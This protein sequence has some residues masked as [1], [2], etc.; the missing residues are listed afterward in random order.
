MVIMRRTI[1]V[2][3]LLALSLS[4]FTQTKESV[5]NQAYYEGQ[6]VGSIDLVANPRIDL[7]PY[8]SLIVQKAGEPYSSDKVA[9]SVKALENTQAFSGVE[10]Q[11]NPDPA[12]LKL[13]FVLE[14]VYYIGMITFPG[15]IKRFSYTRLLQIANLQDQSPYQSSQ[16]QQSESALLRFFA[17]QGYFQAK[18]ALEVK[19]DDQNQLTNIAFHTEL[20]KQARVGK[21]EIVGPPAREGQKLESRLRSLRARFTGALVKTGKPY[22]QTRIRSAMTLIKKELGKQNYLANTVKANPP[23]YHPETN[24]ADVSFEV[25]TGPEVGIHIVGAKLSWLPFLARRR[26]RKSIP[27]YEEA[28]VDPDLVAEGQRNLTSFFQQK[29]FFDVKVTSNLHEQN[30]KIVL[31]YQISKGQKHV[32]QDI[33][34]RGNHHLSNSDLMGQVAVKKRRPLISRGAFSEKLLQTSIAGIEALYKDNGFEQVKVTPDVVDREPRLYVNFNVAEGDRTIV[35]SLKVAGNNQIP[36]SELRPKKGFELEEGKPFSAG[37]ISIDRNKLAAKYLDRGFLNSEVQTIVARHPD[38]WHAVDVTYQIT[39]DQQV[40]ISRVLN[41]G[42]DHTKLHLINISADLS[43][44]EPLSEGKLLAGESKL[45]DLG[46]FDWASI[47]PKKQITNQS[48]EDA[49]IKVHESKRNTVTYGFGLEI[50]RRGGNIPTGTVAV[51]GL[52]TIN[53]GTQNIFPSEKAFVGPRGSVEFIRRNMRGEGETLAISVLAARLDQQLLATYTDPHFR[54]SNWQ[55]LTSISAERTTENPLFAARLADV[56]EQ[57]QRFINAKKTTQ[58]QLR[59][60][61][62]RTRL[63]EILV[64]QLVLPSDRNVDLSYVSGAIIHD[65]RDKPLDAHHGVYQ[66]LDLRIVPSAFGSS[67]NFVRLL[68]QAAYYKPVHAVVFANSLRLGLASPFAGATV[69][70]SQRFFAGG[71]TTLRGFPTDEAGPLRYVP[72]CLAGQ[73]KNCPLVP[74]PIGG[75]QLFIFNSELRYPIPIMRNLGGVVFYD[76]GNVY[77]SVNLPELINNYTNTVGIG[78]RYSTP[79][80]PV[81]FDFGHNLDA[82]RGISA[83]QYFITIGQAF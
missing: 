39:E 30:E 74:V 71:S 65:T 3:A 4:A 9:S 35:S 47:G 21:V 45:Y 12:G 2:L 11:V 63:T 69:P 54:R 41:L 58:L 13:T 79:I 75:N 16:V 73:T 38:D 48:Q 22:S 72:F 64:P 5:G 53:T 23:N 81:R 29:G 55:A 66:T 10:P 83:N 44:E 32:V 34:F 68:G 36:L 20:G 33:A 50:T 1:S 7:E 14:P 17:E 8:R 25:N 67:T 37:R 78:L 46:I 27:I 40:R 18:V 42:Q 76:G 52:P 43:P 80:G 15:A 56:S 24:R 82:A 77:S 51:P 60:E 49:L 62:E 70:T 57:F 61:F 26:K 19:P 31:T 59:Y 6:K 28:S